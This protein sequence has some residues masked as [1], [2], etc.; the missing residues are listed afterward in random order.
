MHSKVV[1]HTNSSNKALDLILRAYEDKDLYLDLSRLNIYDL[2][3][4]IGLLTHLIGLDLSFNNL[5]YLPLEINNLLNLKDLNI[6]YN[7]FNHNNGIGFQFPCYIN[8][9]RIDISYNN[10]CKI[11]QDIFNVDNIGNVILDGNPVMKDVPDSVINEGIFAIDN[12]CEEIYISQITEVLYE[13]KMIF[14]G[15]GEVGK[16]SLMK[17]MI[18]ENFVFNEGRE[19]TTHGINIKDWDFAYN[20]YT[21]IDDLEDKSDEH[22]VYDT[23]KEEEVNDEEEND[24]EGNDDDIIYD[25]DDDYEEE[26]LPCK[27]HVWD[28]GG[29]EIYHSTH[30]FFLTKRSV[31][32]YVWD[33]RKEED[34]TGFEYWLNTI[35]TLGGSSPALI[36]MN[37]AD[38]RSK[39][40]DEASLKKKYSNIQGFYNT[41]CLTDIGIKELK[42]G[43]IKAF[44]KLPHYGDKLPKAWIEI[45]N[46]LRNKNTNYI[47]YKDY[48]EICQIN[49]LNEKR[50]DFLT[51][52]LHDLGDILLYKDD[53][54]LRNTMILNPE[55]LTKAFYKLID[56]E[57]IQMSNGTFSLKDIYNIWDHNEYPPEK[58]YELIRL[59]E[60]F[61]ICFNLLSTDNYI[62]PELLSPEPN[63]NYDNIIKNSI[64]KFDYEFKFMPAGIMPRFIC[65]N[66]L[67]IYAKRY[68]KNGL[69]LRFEDSKALVINN[70]VERKIRI[71]IEGE[72]SDSLLSMIRRDFNMILD[73]LELLKEEDYTE[74]LPCSCELCKTD[75][76]PFYFK[77]NILKKYQ[78]KNKEFITCERSIEDVKIS[79]LLKGYEKISKGN[80][81][82]EHILMACSELQGNQLIINSNEDSRNIFI[83]TILSNRG[84][85]TKDQSRWGSSPTKKAQGEVDIKLGNLD[86][87]IYSI[88]EGLNLK[89][90][91]TSKIHS[92]IEKI[93]NYDLLGL[94]TNYMVVYCEAANYMQLWE[95]YCTIVCMA[96]TKYPLKG[97]CI[98]IT[99]NYDVGSQIKIGKTSYVINERI[100][101]VIHIFINMVP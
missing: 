88:F 8:L 4:E 44:E 38:I 10:F 29:Q 64:I 67:S 66:F 96:N 13:A 40:I 31:Y 86:N 73:S 48:N 23:I 94:D 18:D 6:S 99:D 71:Y 82:I 51:D 55:W 70:F 58:H 33:A 5:T 83:A 39:S 11:P 43:V 61:E 46:E 93:F 47:A 100:C 60:R 28:F 45:R 87:T 16:T 41:S 25:D 74:M 54:V 50:A 81:L 56:N 80:K 42:L 15:Q 37:K 34:Y 22:T 76:S 19:L 90:A 14:V 75:N 32:I 97:R 59:M 79:K 35:R 53:P 69:I 49:G 95:K 12:Y 57:D 21:L 27:L 101:S 92:H 85:L 89:T 17:K 2:P 63:F 3:S 78:S 98:D 26:L 1:A 20:E 52:Y 62:I 65:K 84:V 77:F 72:D 36:V 91:E 9:N 30:Q 7:C 68:W 24:D